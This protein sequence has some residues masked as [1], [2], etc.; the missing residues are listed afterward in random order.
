MR[1]VF[2]RNVPFAVAE[3]GAGEAVV[4]LHG[5]TGTSF[6]WQLL[7]QKLSVHYHVIAPDLIGHGASAVPDD[8]RRYS[9][10]EALL[11]LKAL[12]SQRGVRKFHLL[13]YSMG[14]RL[15]L[16]FAVEHPE[17]LY[18]LILES[19]SPGLKLQKEREERQNS[20]NALADWLEREGIEAF[21]TRWTNLPLFASQAKL[22]LVTQQALRERRLKNAPQGLANSLRGMGTGTQPS[23]WPTLKALRLPTLLVAGELDQKFTCLAKAMAQELPQSSLSLVAQAGHTIHLEQPDIFCEIV[24]NFLTK[25]QF[26]KTAI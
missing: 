26:N 15:A 22:P 21:V 10:E 6:D 19:A 5:F 24:T 1:Q 20:D 25:H 17:L 13:G 9:Q 7:M 4:L 14:G 12:L 16:R 2:V 3:A 11:D 18:S 23:L 8:W